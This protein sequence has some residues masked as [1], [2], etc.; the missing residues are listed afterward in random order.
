MEG[1]DYWQTGFAGLVVPAL[2]LNGWRAEDA[3]ILLALRSPT[4]AHRRS[5]P[6]EASPSQGEASPL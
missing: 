5:T 4:S 1:R 3:R 6:R 2:R